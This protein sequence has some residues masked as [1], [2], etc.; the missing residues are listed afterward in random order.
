MATVIN[1]QINRNMTKLENCIN[2]SQCFNCLRSLKKCS[3][4]LRTQI[5]SFVFITALF[6][7]TNA[8]ALNAGAVSIT[9]ETSPLLVLDSNSPCVGPQSAYVAFKVTNTSGATLNNLEIT[10]GNF[11]ASFVLA[12]GQAAKQYIGTL[13]NG[14]SDVV[15]WFISYPCTIGLSRSLS[16]T[17]NDTNSGVVSNSFTITTNSSISSNAGGLITS[18]TISGSATIGKIIYIDVVYTFGGASNGDR[19]NLQPAGNASFAAGCYQLTN[20]QI[21]A[22]AVTAIPVNSV[23]K[24]FYTATTNQP[25]R[26]CR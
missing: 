1:K 11:G 15:Y 25:V 24:I 23:D 10:L 3:I 4:L 18:Q 16:A 22:S 17:V 20:S 12:G 8:F 9:M 7:S 26:R 13:A 5:L 19:Y 21:I 6:S 2:K 14:A